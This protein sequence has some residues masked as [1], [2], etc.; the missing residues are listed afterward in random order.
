MSRLQRTLKRG[1]LVTLLAMVLGTTV[2]PT[3]S[4]A[5][6]SFGLHSLRP[7]D[8]VGDSPLVP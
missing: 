2:L 1:L 7:M 3:T 8:G 4:M 5:M 6:P